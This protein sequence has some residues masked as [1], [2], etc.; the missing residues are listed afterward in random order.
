MKVYSKSVEIITRKLYEFVD[1]EERIDEV[2]GESGVKAGFCLIR[3]CHTTA[4]LVVTEKDPSVHKDFVRNLEKVLPTKQEWNH[5]YE[6]MVNARA[7]QAAAWLGSNHWVL[8]NGGKPVFGTWQ[9][10]FFVELF[11][12][13]KRS[14]ELVVV[15]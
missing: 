5:S 15:G 12:G 1:L 6:G 9:G 2:V 8:V 13:R 11:E 10:V 7:H 3:I 4:A 14:I